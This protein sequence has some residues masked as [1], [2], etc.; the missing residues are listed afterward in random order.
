M[1]RLIVKKELYDS[2][3]DDDKFLDAIQLCRILSAIQYNNNIYGLLN[4]H[5]KSEEFDTYIQ[6]HLVIL[7]SAFLYEGIKKF[8]TIKNNW[9]ELESL[10][11]FIA[12][13]EIIEEFFSAKNSFYSEILYNIRRKVAFHF[14]G[15]VVVSKL[16]EFLSKSKTEDVFFVESKTDLNKDMK[17]SLANNLSFHYILGLI[18]GDSD[19]EKFKSFALKLTELSNLFCDTLQVIIPELIEDYCN[20]EEKQ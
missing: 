6:L 9:K 12:N 4:E 1:E 7:H 5:V 2:I 20:F 3:K 11:S 14:D 8:N 17:F 10:E 19:K 15:H 18:E 13:K 16:E